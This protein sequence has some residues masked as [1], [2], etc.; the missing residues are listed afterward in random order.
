MAHENKLFGFRPTKEL[1][2]AFRKKCKLLR[3]KDG[4]TTYTKVLIELIYLWTKGKVR[5]P[6]EKK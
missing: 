2:N 1:A 6:G 5:I 3:E 4:Y